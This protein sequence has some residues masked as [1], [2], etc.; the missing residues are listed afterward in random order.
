MSLLG[1]IV[2]R[3]LFP[4][5]ELHGI[6]VLDGAFSPNQR[7]DGARQLG[8]EIERPDDIAFGQDGALYVSTGNNILRCTGDDFEARNVFATLDGPV[9]GLASAPDGRLARTSV[10]LSLICWRAK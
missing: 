7:L 5:R 8:A 4:N 1:D 6:P 3:V 10:S 9:G 2:D